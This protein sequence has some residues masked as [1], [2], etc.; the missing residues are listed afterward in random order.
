[1]ET[2]SDRTLHL[3]RETIRTYR[4]RRLQV[5]AADRYPGILMITPDVS[6]LKLHTSM[7]VAWEDIVNTLYGYPCPVCLLLDICYPS[8]TSG[9]W[10][11]DHMKQA[12]R[13]NLITAQAR[14]D[15]LRSGMASWLRFRVSPKMYPTSVRLALHREETWVSN[16]TRINGK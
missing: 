9:W 14:G 3:T 8:L 7:T 13:M 16:Y 11:A 2:H 10:Q 4:A 5:P 12:W 6:W 1:M 15:K